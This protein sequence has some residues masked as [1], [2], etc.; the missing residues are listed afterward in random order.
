MEAGEAR[1]SLNDR[2]II[3]ARL[4]LRPLV[5]AN[6]DTLAAISRDEAVMAFVGDG[7]PRLARHPGEA[8]LR[9]G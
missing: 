3:T 7:K 2:E 4:R 6:L 9:R 8:R 1:S 5:E